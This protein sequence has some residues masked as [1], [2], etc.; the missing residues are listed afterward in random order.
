MPTPGGPG[1]EH[2]AEVP[3]SHPQDVTLAPVTTDDVAR[4]PVYLR[5]SRKVPRIAGTL[6]L[7][8]GLLNITSAIT[9]RVRHRMNPLTP[10]IPG[11][12]THAALAA[13]LVA[14]IMLLLLAHSLVR[15]KR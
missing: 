3:G 11:A 5:H 13:T 9:P 2:A 1:G 15:R 12:L 7:L 14:G 10:F 6:C 8:L 4:Q